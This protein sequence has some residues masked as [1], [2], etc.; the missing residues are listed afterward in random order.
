MNR[1]DDGCRDSV[2]ARHRWTI[3]LVAATLTAVACSPQGGVDWEEPPRYVFS[4][5]A[6]CDQPVHG[7][8]IVTVEAGDVVD[9]VPVEGS[10]ETFL[11]ANGV[12]GLPTLR[13]ILASAGNGSDIT[14]DEEGVPSRVRS[15]LDGGGDVCFDILAFT[16]PLPDDDV[17]SIYA[18]TISRVCDAAEPHGG[19]SDR[20]EVSERFDAGFGAALLPMPEPVRETIETELPGAVF[21]D[22]DGATEG[23]V[24]LLIGPYEIVRD[25]VVRVEAGYTCGG[26]C[27]TGR[28]WYYQLTDGVWEPTSAGAVGEVDSRWEA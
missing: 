19:C 24:R 16:I 2:T 6:Y 4:M 14:F 18:Q 17:R 5:N 13:E 26:L 23:T 22:S 12:D 11:R 10:A 1:T 27:G 15:S 20:V 3:L 21:T 25:G 7:R 9:A 28:T 8:F